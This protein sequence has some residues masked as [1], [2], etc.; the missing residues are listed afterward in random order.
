MVPI[1]LCRQLPESVRALQQTQP[2]RQ[3]LRRWLRLC[4]H[5]PR[6]APAARKAQARRKV[7]TLITIGGSPND[8]TRGL[9]LTQL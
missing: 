8:L 4:P 1:Q 3:V 9:R 5:L 2:A 6:E 7:Q